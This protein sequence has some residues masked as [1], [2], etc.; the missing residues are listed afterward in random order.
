MSFIK[1]DSY[2]RWRQEGFEIK[3]V[4]SLSDSSFYPEA[5][6]Q[7]QSQLLHVRY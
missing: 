2:K 6:Q 1:P 4:L 3:L 7:P 5:T